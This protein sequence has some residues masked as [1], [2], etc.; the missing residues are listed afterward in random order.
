[1]N[2]FNSLYTYR[3]LP[4]LD[5]AKADGK[6][7]AAA[8]PNT[9]LTPAQ[10]AALTQ[11]R[12]ENDIA[13][14]AGADRALIYNDPA[15]DYSNPIAAQAARWNNHAI[16]YLNHDL[17][18]AFRCLRDAIATDPSSATPWNNLGL[19]YLQI[20]DLKQAKAHFQQAINRDETLDTAYG[21]AGLAALEAR[22][23]NTAWQRLNQAHNLDPNEPV[24]CN[25]LGI[26]CLELGLSQEAI[27]W[28]NRATTL[29]PN[30][31]KPYYNRGRAY[32]QLDDYPQANQ[33]IDKG[34]LLDETWEQRA[35]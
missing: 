30:L 27:L 35:A 25:S 33:N 8:Q 26:F 18:R 11:Q 14:Q 3:C 24:H 19:I 16:A 6:N 4:K 23:Y 12:S 1:M 21:N 31:P 17:S 34:L 7:G 10:I 9:V 15:P 5:P 32:I 20:A 28:F 2:E 29:E 22:D 13:Q